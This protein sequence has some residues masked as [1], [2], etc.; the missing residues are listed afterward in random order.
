L[1]SEARAAFGESSQARCFIAGD[2]FEQIDAG[3]GRGGFG[4]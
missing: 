4:S 3:R 2:G 1:R